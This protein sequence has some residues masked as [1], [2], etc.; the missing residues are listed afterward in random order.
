MRSQ[1]S[2]VDCSFAS[3]YDESV[4]KVQ[5][6]RRWRV[7]RVFPA[8]GKKHNEIQPIICMLIYAYS[9]QDGGRMV[10]EEYGAIL[11]D[12]SSEPDTKT[13]A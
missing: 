4:F 13:F 6:L 1:S 2:K 7:F 12:L 5:R 10:V 3:F 11:E 9:M 8:S